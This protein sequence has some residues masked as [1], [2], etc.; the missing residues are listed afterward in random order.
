MFFFRYLTYLNKDIFIKKL[1]LI[2]I[3]LSVFALIFSLIAL[4][5]GDLNQQKYL[6]INQIKYHQD[7]IQ[8]SSKKILKNKFNLLRTE[9][10]ALHYFLSARE[11]KLTNL[12]IVE[13]NY[14]YSLQ[15]AIR[16]SVFDMKRITDLANIY[17]TKSWKTDHL[18]KK[19]NFTYLNKSVDDLNR[20]FLSKNLPTICQSKT[21]I[22][23]KGILDQQKSF[24]DK[25]LYLIKDLKL[26]SKQRLDIA[27]KELNAN[28]HKTTTFII[29]AFIIQ[30]LIF[31]VI[32]FL[33][34][35][36]VFSFGR[37]K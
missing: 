19:Y 6:E 22:E 8:R 11:N 20:L 4:Y 21:L 32:N 13:S 10:D 17:L 5:F 15:Q 29:I 36:S 30:L 33:D 1:I 2:S 7:L 31:L 3:F 14:C 24:N 35:R 37:K 34:V 25:L 23:V 27:F 12:N 26:I 9:K 16:I 28:F 18:I